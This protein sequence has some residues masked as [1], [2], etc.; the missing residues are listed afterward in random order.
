MLF[1]DLLPLGSYDGEP[2][3]ELHVPWDFVYGYGEKISS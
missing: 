3:G 1:K 2:N